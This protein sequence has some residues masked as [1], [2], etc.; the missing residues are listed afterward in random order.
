MLLDG[1][2]IFADNLGDRDS[3]GGIDVQAERLLIR[4]GY[5]TTDVRGAGRGGAITIETNDLEVRDGAS[6]GSI[7]RN[8]LSLGDSERRSEIEKIERL[9]A[10]AKSG[11]ITIHADRFLVAGKNNEFTQVAASTGGI[12]GAGQ[13][14]ITAEKKS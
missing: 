5:L 6:I 4:G 10:T 1:A 8:G 3:I 11:T 9:S 14:S 2:W 12:G 13:I 7:V